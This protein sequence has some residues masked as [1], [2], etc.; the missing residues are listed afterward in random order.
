MSGLLSLRRVPYGTSVPQRMRKSAGP[1]ERFR[2][3]G[4]PSP[5]H[6]SCIRGCSCLAR[7]P[8]S[9][10]TKQRRQPG[11]AEHRRLFDCSERARHHRR[12]ATVRERR[13]LIRA[14][15]ATERSHNH[16]RVPYLAEGFSSCP[17]HPLP[18]AGMTLEVPPGPSPPQPAS[19]RSPYL[20]PGTGFPALRVHSDVAEEFGK[21]VHA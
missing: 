17:V 20:M 11:I 13:A 19:T 2:E 1:I 14:A 16:A 3:P 8:D 18:I 10:K 12:A 15:T 9:W 5:I 6:S 7:H 4:Y 21:R